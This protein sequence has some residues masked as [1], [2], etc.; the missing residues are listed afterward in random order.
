MGSFFELAHED[1]GVADGLGVV[2]DTKVG[3]ILVLDL[4]YFAYRGGGRGGRSSS[5]SISS[6]IVVIIIHINIV[7]VV[8][9]VL[10]IVVG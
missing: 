7:V 5:S 10:N 2:G 4:N 6:I 8:V 1:E 3:P 9:I